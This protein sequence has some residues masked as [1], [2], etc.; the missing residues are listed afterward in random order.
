MGLDHENL[1]Q[2]L[3]TS[4]SHLPELKCTPGMLNYS[5]AGTPFA[6]VGEQ[7]SKFSDTT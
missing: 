4:F 3:P 6:S 5:E 1:S 2:I 7:G